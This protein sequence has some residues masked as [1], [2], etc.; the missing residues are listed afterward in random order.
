[1]RSVAVMNHV[2]CLRCCE[3]IGPARLEEGR[4]FQLSMVCLTL[5]LMICFSAMC[6]HIAHANTEF[7]DEGLKFAESL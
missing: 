5:S 3:P 2:T 4:P 7:D 6:Q 1:M